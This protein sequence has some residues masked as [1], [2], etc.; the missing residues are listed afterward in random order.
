MKIMFV[1]SDGRLGQHDA[2]SRWPAEAF[3]LAQS[4]LG[5]TRRRGWISS[6][7]IRELGEEGSDGRPGST[8]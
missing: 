6:A 1:A 4:R 3:G 8:A 7:C 5:H 2:G